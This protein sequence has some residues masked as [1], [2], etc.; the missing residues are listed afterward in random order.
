MESNPR[1]CRRA[2][3]SLKSTIRSLI[4]YNTYNGHTLSEHVRS[5]LERLAR[6]EELEDEVKMLR[7]ENGVL[8]KLAR[9][10]HALTEQS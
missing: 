1:L 10:G 9:M 6:L 3:N 8:K 4:I 2:V 5:C 7:E